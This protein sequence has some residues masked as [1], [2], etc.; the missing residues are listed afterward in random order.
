MWTLIGIILAICFA[1]FI[2]KIAFGAIG[3]AFKLVFWI[4]QGVFCLLGFILGGGLLAILGA[5][6]IGSIVGVPILLFAGRR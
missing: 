4:L 5:V 3:F 2:F 6:I 1:G